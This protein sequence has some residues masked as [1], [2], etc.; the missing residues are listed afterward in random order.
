L[1]KKEEVYVGLLDEVNQAVPGG[2]SKPL[3]IALGALLVHRMMSGGSAQAD[4]APSIVP[5]PDA[6]AP[7]PDGGLLGGLG[8][9]VNKLQQAGHGETVNSWVGSGPNKPIDPG[10]LAKALGPQNVNAAAQ[11]SGMNAQDLV[12]QLAQALPGVVDQLTKSGRMPTLQE[13]ATALT[14]QKPAGS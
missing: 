4:Q 3:M 5:Q 14:Q 2:I 12:T 1:H 6:N 9:L 10:S 7:T 11:Q 8:G 13:L